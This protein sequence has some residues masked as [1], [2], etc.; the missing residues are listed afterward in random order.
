MIYFCKS[1]R[2][3]ANLPIKEINN[4][5]KLRRYAIILDARHSTQRL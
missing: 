1:N 2:D 4:I 3:N 5:I